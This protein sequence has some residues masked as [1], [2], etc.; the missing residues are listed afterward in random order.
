MKKGIMEYLADVKKAL[1]PKMMIFIVI[2]VIA[3]IIHPLIGLIFA[4][5]AINFLM[6]FYTSKGVLERDPSE[7]ASEEEHKDINTAE[8]EEHPW[9]M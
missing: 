8:T 1:T 7:P 3:F 2:G 9:N 6:S 4:G 5:V